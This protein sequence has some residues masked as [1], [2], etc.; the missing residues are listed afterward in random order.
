MKCTNTL[1]NDAYTIVCS[2]QHDPVGRKH[3]RQ[4]TV[5]HDEIMDR[6]R[7][8]IGPCVHRHRPS[9]MH[10]LQNG[11]KA[12]TESQGKIIMCIIPTVYHRHTF[13]NGFCRRLS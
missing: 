4:Y 6:Y 8:Y 10:H 11:S 13:I 7:M 9:W 5:V 3:Q 12:Q 2:F 1:L